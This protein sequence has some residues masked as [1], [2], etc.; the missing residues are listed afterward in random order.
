VHDQV[1][2]AGHHGLGHSGRETRCRQQDHVGQALEGIGGAVGVAGRERTVVPGVEGLEHVECLG[3][4]NLSNNDSVWTH[5][6]GISDQVPHGDLSHTFTVGR[7]C[8]EPDDVGGV[9]R[10]FSGILDREMELQ[11][12]LGD[13]FGGLN[14]SLCRSLG[15]RTFICFTMAEI[16]TDSRRLRLASCGSP[17]PLH[18]HN[19]TITELKI[20]GYPLGVTENSTYDVIEAQLSAGDYLVMYSDGIPE[21]VNA[22]KTMF[23]YGQTI[24]TVREACAEGIAA[25]ELVDR[26]MLRARRFAGDEPQSDDMTCVVV[27]V[28][29]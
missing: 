23:G 28:E 13:R 4:A 1:D 15:E 6:Q 27:K 29:G 5:T 26:L 16:D 20:D 24:N 12:E 3:P 19:D 10:Q 8:L 2:A 7:A 21:T 22:D 14:R 18:V 25:E 17:Y 11:I 9:E